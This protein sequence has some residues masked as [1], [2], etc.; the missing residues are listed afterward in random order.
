MHRFDLVRAPGPD[1]DAAVLEV[2]RFLNQL[3]GWDL[4]ELPSVPQGGAL[5][6]LLEAAA[7]DGFLTE[8]RSSLRS[9]Y[10]DIAEWNKEGGSWPAHIKPEFRR[11]VTR[12]M[13]RLESQGPV[14]VLRFEHAN[15][16]IL[17]QFYNLEGSGWKGKESSA[18]ACNQATL[19][20]YGE[21]ARSAE[22][23]GYL[24][25]YFLEC[26]GRMLASHFGITYRGKYFCPK[27][28][29]G[30]NYRTLGPGHLLMNAVLRDCVARG[31]S[32][33]DILGSCEEW[34]TRWTPL[35][36]SQ[37]HWYVFN[38]G[39]YGGLLHS[40]RFRVAPAVRRRFAQKKD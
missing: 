23:L 30:E 36:H 40:L 22:R 31:L 15:Q 12:R 32:E 14:H 10:I 26:G 38:K 20:F 5:E 39:A 17:Q 2:W 24:S 18:I 33:L 9:P 29:Y 35:V 16:E 25:L 7:N 19:R 13:K 1:G 21:I 3:P 6:Q 4:I 28:A 11:E 37:S 27:T 8:S 34:K